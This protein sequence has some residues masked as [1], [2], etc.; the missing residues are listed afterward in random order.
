MTVVMMI[1]LIKYLEIDVSPMPRLE[2]K[3]VDL[4]LRNCVPGLDDAEY[5]ALMAKK[6]SH[7]KPLFD[8]V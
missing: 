3:V 7:T 4:L 2:A 8:T 5:V 1:K 6:Y